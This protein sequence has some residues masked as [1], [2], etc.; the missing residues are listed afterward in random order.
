MS[1]EITKSSVAL[2]KTQ[3]VRSPYDLSAYVSWSRPNELDPRELDAKMINAISYRFTAPEVDML[4]DMSNHA[5]QDT[6][7]VQTVATKARVDGPITTNT[8]FFK[9]NKDLGKGENAFAVMADR[10]P[11]FTHGPGY[12]TMGPNILLAHFRDDL[13]GVDR[14]NLFQGDVSMVKTMLEDLMQYRKENELAIL[15]TIVSGLRADN[16]SESPQ[17]AEGV[18]KMLEFCKVGRRPLSEMGLRLRSFCQTWDLETGRA[19]FS[20]ASPHFQTRVYVTNSVKLAKYL[21]RC[22]VGQRDIDRM[23]TDYSYASRTLTK[24]FLDNSYSQ[25]FVDLDSLLRDY[26]I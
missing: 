4:C 22:R 10:N 19:N 17:V 9:F 26:C 24:A 1:S 18:L 7:G 15:E 8:P 14:F 21:S 23:F 25:K 12:C 6:G 3:N 11:P 16:A 13:F 20:V 5:I 2:P